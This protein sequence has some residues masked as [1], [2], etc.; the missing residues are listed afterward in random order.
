MIKNITKYKNYYILFDT[1]KNKYFIICGQYPH[2]KGRFSLLKS[3]KRY[4][5]ENMKEYN[6]T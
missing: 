4:I 3:V 2:S 5:D 6:V 1:I